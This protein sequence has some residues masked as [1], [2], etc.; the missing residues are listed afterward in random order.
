MSK[1]FFI[2]SKYVDYKD[3]TIHVEDR[4]LQFADSVYEVVAFYNKKLIDLKFHFDRLRF[5]LS[6][7]NINYNFEDRKIT[8]IFN[9]LIEINSLKNGILYLQHVDN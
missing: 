4:G 6:E 9:K 7:L 5:S 2:N 3:A 1:K 8:K